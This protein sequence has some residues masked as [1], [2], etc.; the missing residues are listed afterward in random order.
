MRW[1]EIKLNLPG[2]PEY[3]P[4]KPRVMKWN[5]LITRIAGDIVGFID[6]LRATGHSREY[7][8]AVA[9]RQVMARLQYLGIQDAP[10]KRRPPSQ[11]PGA[12]AGSIFLTT[13]DQVTKLV[14]KEKW[15]KVQLMIKEMLDNAG[16]TWG[17]LIH[18]SA[19]NRSGASYVIRQ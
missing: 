5:R 12:W 2:D 11:T 14:T 18:I 3:N 1:D 16:E 4:S 9:S 8:W 7:A 10:R 17:M 6:D 19:L 15:V 13:D